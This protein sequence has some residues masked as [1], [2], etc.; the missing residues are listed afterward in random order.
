MRGTM[1]RRAM[2]TMALLILAAGVWGCGGQGKPTPTPVSEAGPNLLVESE[3]KVSLKRKGW[4]DYVPVSF[5]VEVR[6]GDLV[7]PDEGQEIRILCADLSLH[8]VT[9][10][11]GCP[12]KVEVPVLQYG[13][14][15][16]LAPRAPN[17]LIPYVLHPRNT[18]VLDAH[19]VLRWYDTGASSYTVAIVRGGEVVW[20]AAGVKGGE[21]RYPEDA[22]ALQPG[23]DYLLRVQ[24]GDSQRHSGEEPAMGLG[25]R[26]LSDEARSRVEAQREEILALPLSDAARRFAL[27][28]YYNGKGLRGEALALLD[29]VSLD[30]RAAA[31]QLM[32]GDL[33]LAV[34]L[35]EEAAR[36]FQEALQ[37]AE[38][39]GDLESQAAAYVGLWRAGRGEGY[40]DDGVEA[41]EKLGAEDMVEALQ[42]EKG[43]VP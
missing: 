5:G 27:A 34:S 33:L 22:P 25:F 10:E 20:K 3:G 37:S 9:R 43:R 18:A 13:A 41:Y 23:V 2:R 36:A 40:F 8:R 4:R 1:K 12:C 11:S 16:V 6:R 28:V 14:R 15:R 35:P 21:M 19:P 7:R 29:E 30:V 26:V 24:D 38:A 32:R 42:K 17:R 39:L 31:V